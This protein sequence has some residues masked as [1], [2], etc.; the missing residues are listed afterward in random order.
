MTQSRKVPSVKICGI[1]EEQTLRAMAGL[2][3]EYVGVVFA[4]SKRQVTAGQAAHLEQAA[5]T[6]AL[7]NGR[8]ARTVGVFVNPTLGQLAEVLAQV[9]LD[10]VQLH[11]QETPAFCREVGQTFGVE[12]W[13][14]LSVD[15][16]ALG[17]SRNVTGPARLADYEGVVSTV[18]IDTAGGGTG[19]TFRW[20]IIPFYPAQA[21]KHGMRLF[22]AGGLTP[23]NITDLLAGHSPDGVDISSGVETGGT[24]DINKIAVFAERVNRS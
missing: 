9:Q 23:D 15:E 24:K 13:R 22:I 5:R 4:P 14:A 12:V 10:V 11:G 17:G 2:P 21:R 3:V 16:F 20:E 18:L 1:R 7:K 6:I 19:H 8:P